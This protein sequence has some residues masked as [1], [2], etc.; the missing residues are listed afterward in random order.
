M[1]RIPD[2][3]RLEEKQTFIGQLPCT[4]RCAGCITVL[5]Y[6]ISLQKYKLGIHIVTLQIKRLKLREATIWSFI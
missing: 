2:G 3:K 4:R 6:L 1:E 5:C